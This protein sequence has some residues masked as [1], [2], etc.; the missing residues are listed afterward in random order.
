MILLQW[1]QSAGTFSDESRD[2]KGFKRFEPRYPKSKADFLAM[3][4][5]R[6]DGCGLTGPIPEAIGYC[7][8]LRRLS[9]DNN[10]LSG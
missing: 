2:V 6:L 5:L 4:A 9:L 7:I 10:A 1:V 3:T 8:K